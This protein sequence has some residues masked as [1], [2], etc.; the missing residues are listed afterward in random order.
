MIV[1]GL[2]EGI[3]HNVQPLL[4]ECLKLLEEHE[5]AIIMMSDKAQSHLNGAVNMTADTGPCNIS[6]ISQK[7][8]A[9]CGVLL[10]NMPSLAHT[11]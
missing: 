3:I 5:D 11:F 1:Q 7:T 10:V 6:I 8:T 2:N 4:R 9:Q